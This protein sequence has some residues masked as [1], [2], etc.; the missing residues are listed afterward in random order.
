METVASA[1]KL[2]NLVKEC[3]SSGIQSK[4]S[5]RFKNN[6]D[7]LDP[8]DIVEFAKEGDELSI[9][10]LSKVGQALG[11]GLA[12]I[13]QLLNPEI[14]VF[15]GPLSK[16]NQYVITPIQQS[17]NQYCLEK[18]SKNIYLEISELDDMNGLLGTT[19]ML[20]Q[21]AFS[22]SGTQELLNTIE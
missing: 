12:I 5:N 9:A 11:K 20:F 16:A 18:F 19:A 14:I 15:H 8:A 3:L 22:T 2:V 10:A 7:D 21:N 6:P 17:L 4:L 1:T 13:I